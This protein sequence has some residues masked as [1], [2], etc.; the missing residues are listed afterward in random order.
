MKEAEEQA[1]KETAHQTQMEVE[2]NEMREKVRK[3]ES[4][5]I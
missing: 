4:E 1:Q 2:L 3:L 5:C